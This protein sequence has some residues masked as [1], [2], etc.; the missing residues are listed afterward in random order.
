AGKAEPM[1]SV[2]LNDSASD[3]DIGIAVIRMGKAYPEEARSQVKQLLQQGVAEDEIEKQTGVSDRTIRRWKLELERYGRIGKPP[4]SRTGRHR[5]MNKDVEQA[6]FDRVAQKPDMSVDDMLWWLYD[7][8]K[9]VV[10]TRTIRRAFERRNTSHKKFRTD[11][12]KHFTIDMGVDMDLDN[13]VNVHVDTQHHDDHGSMQNVVQD[14]TPAPAPQAHM[15]VSQPDTTYQSPY[16]PLMAMADATDDSGQPPPPDISPELARALGGLTEST[17]LHQDLMPDHMDPLSEDE[18]TLQLQLQQIMLQK[19]EVELKLKMR[20]LRQRRESHTPNDDSLFDHLD[21]DTTSTSHMHPD[22]TANNDPFAPQPLPSATSSTTPKPRDSRSK[23][24]VQEARK[25]TEERQER[26]LKDLERRSRRREHLTAEWVQSRDVWAKGPEKLLVQLMHKHS[27]YAYN[28]NSLETF[29]A[30]FAELYHLVDHT[31]WYAP[32]HDDLLRER[33]RRKMSQLR[34]KMVKS[35]E[36]ISR[37]EGYGGWTKPD[38]H[39]A[40]AGAS[41]LTGTAPD[42]DSLDL[43]Q[44]HQINGLSMDLHTHDSNHDAL[45]ARDAM[46]QHDHSMLEHLQGNTNDLHHT[47]FDPDQ[48]AR[49]QNELL[50]QRGI[51]H[52]E[53]MSNQRAIEETMAAGLASV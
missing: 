38:D 1:L 29:E 33:T 51:A 48:L 39:D 36:I 49:H 11:A 9:L 37:G 42:D 34:S 22:S 7:T 44:H 17:T 45:M 21:V 46:M 32:V 35:G 23:S 28:Q 24:K 31:E 4:E 50:A 30:I 5:V 27:T 2:T 3:R 14:P 8:Y 41:D 10:G 6:L 13:D 53:H 25:R 26:M 40:L 12:R 16:A 52:Q 20:R 15:A 43:S 47:D 18:E 19:K